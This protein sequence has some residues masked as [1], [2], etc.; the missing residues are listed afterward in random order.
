VA[1]KFLLGVGKPADP[2]CT[3]GER[4]RWRILTVSRGVGERELRFIAASL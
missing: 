4:E 1:G 2:S 3:I